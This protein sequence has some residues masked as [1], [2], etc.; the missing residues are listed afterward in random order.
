MDLKENKSEIRLKR[1]L[2]K[3]NQHKKEQMNTPEMQI[4]QGKNHLY[5]QVFLKYVCLHDI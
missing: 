1:N 5:V 3:K 2:A 4:T